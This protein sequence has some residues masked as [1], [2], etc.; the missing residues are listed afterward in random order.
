MVSGDSVQVTSQK[1]V[2]NVIPNTAKYSTHS[3][4]LVVF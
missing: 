3:S 4:M 2:D 1:V